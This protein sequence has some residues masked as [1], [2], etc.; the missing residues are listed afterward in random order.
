MGRLGHPNMPETAHDA[1]ALAA[2]FQ[3]EHIST[4]SVR[5]SDDEM[6]RWHTRL[7]HELDV[8][9]LVSMIQP[10][11]LSSS[12]DTMSKFAALIGKNIERAS[13]AA[14]YQRLLDVHA[15]PN[16]DALLV[17][18]EAGAGFYLV[19]LDAWQSLVE[20]DWKSWTVAVKERT[21]CKGWNLFMPL[22]VALSGAVHGPEMSDVVAFLGEDGVMARLEDACKA[23]TKQQ[24][25]S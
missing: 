22:R 15:P 17:L 1:A 18:K 6:W 8:E 9:A 19:A 20:A 10:Y 21:G 3:A 4:S 16:A 25:V 23:C 14:H 24:E 12:S 13:D 5:W 2:H 7:L 11:V